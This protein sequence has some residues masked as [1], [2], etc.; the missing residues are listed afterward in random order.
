MQLYH[1]ITFFFCHLIC[2]SIVAQPAPAKAQSQYIRLT[3][4]T[5]HIGNG[6]L[7]Q[8]GVLDFDKG[9]IKY[10]GQANAAPQLPAQARTIDAKKQEVYPGIIA[11]NSDLGLAEVQQV[12]ATQDQNEIGTFNPHVRSIIAYNTDS[13]VIPTTRSNGVLLAQ[14]VPEG[15]RISGSSSLV[16]LDA[17]NWEDAIFAADLGIQLHWPVRR[18][19]LSKSDEPGSGPKNDDY[20]KAIIEINQFFEDAR[21]YIPMQ[22]DGLPNLRFASMREVFTGQRRVFI[23]ANGPKEMQDATL[24]AENLGLKFVIVGGTGAEHIIPFLQAHK[25]AIVLNRIHRLPKLEEDLVD[26]PFK[27]PA[28]L[29]NAGIL[30]ALSGSEAM[31]LRNIPFVAGTSAGFGISSERALQSITLDAARILGVEKDLGSL[32]LGKSATFFISAGD[33]LDMK[34]NDVTQAFILGKEIDLDNKHKE[35]YR[36][37][38]EKFE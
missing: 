2:G 5:L 23:E 10:V 11:L 34:G 18:I 8:N 13:R 22:N 9:I 35:L 27:L 26:A 32:E 25:V 3:N 33:A 38:S 16:Q 14:I 28:M 20:Q 37:F 1:T 12:R 21:A 29:A 6:Q 4:A 19:N 36:R 17:W 30:Y 31:Q 7:I 24:F 15:G